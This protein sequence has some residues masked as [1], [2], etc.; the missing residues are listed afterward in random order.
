MSRRHGKV[1]AVHDV[2][3][4][5]P[6]N[7]VRSLLLARSGML[8][9]GT[10]LGISGLEPAGSFIHYGPDNG[11]SDRIVTALYED[12]RSTLWIGTSGGLYHLVE[13]R[14]TKDVNEWGAPFA[15]VSCITED[16]EGNIWV[17]TTE[18][19]HRL[20]PRCFRAYTK[21]DRAMERERTRIARDIHDDLGARLTKICKLSERAQRLAPDS[22]AI[23]QVRSIHG[24]AQ[25]MLGRLD[26]TVWA[27]NPRNDRLDRLADYILHYAEEFFRQT[28]VRCRLK[29][30]GEVPALAIA[31]EARHHLFLAVKEALNNAARHSGA[32]EV[33]LQMEYA[34]GAFRIQ[35]RDNGRGFRASEA[36]AR[37]RGLEN[38]RSRLESLAGRWDLQTQPGQGTA[39]TIEFNV[40]ASGLSPGAARS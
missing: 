12:R 14:L 31:A 11:L 30:V 27:V 19:L 25:E 6:H 20:Q 24:T 32:S 1:L 39:I 40:A 38:M 23:E 18:G 35:V 3:S 9:V 7:S 10:M 28:D 5:L 2:T 17:A 22:P 8:W 26:E 21:Q 4:G 36:L 29:V 34:D 37:G 33:Q 13:G 15:S 16:L